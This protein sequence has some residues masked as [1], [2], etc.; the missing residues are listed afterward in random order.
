MDCY[1]QYP[2]TVRLGTVRRGSILGTLRH[3]RTT[4]LGL[5]TGHLGKATHRARVVPSP[6][7][8]RVANRRVLLGPRG[9]RIANSFGVHNTCGGVT[10]LARRRVTHNVIATSTNGRT[11]NI[12]CTTHRH[13]TGT[14]VYVPRVAPPLGIS[15]AGTCNTSIILCNS[16]FSRSTTRTTRLTSGRNVVCIPPFSSCRIVYNRNAVN[17]RVLRSIPGI[18]SIIIPLNNN[19]L[20]TN[21]TLTVGAFGPRIHMVNTVPRNSPT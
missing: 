10:S 21:I 17:L 15:T 14:A 12:T 5:T 18:A 4:R 3:S 20:N 13:N 11:R 8:D 1:F 6:M 7:L 9:L 16:I 19:N 2:H